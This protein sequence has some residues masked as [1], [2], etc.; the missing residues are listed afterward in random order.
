MTLRRRRDPCFGPK[1]R[2]SARHSSR[3][4]RSA[5]IAPFLRQIGSQA[6]L[7]RR[8]CISFPSFDDFQH[9]KARLHEAHIK[10]LEL[11]RDTCTSITTLELS[12]PSGHP[13]SYSTACK[14][15]KQ[16]ALD[17]LDA[18]FKA[19]PSL[20]E[21]I[22]NFKVHSEEDLSYTNRINMRD[23]GWTVK[24]T[25]LRKIWISDDDRVEFD[26]EEDCNAY[27]YEQ[28][29]LDWQREEKKEKEWL[30]WFEAGCKERS[31][32]L[33]QLWGDF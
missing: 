8:I 10:N 15:V 5:H 22:V 24:V 28:C 19:V 20:K 26:N 4:I 18:R 21:I 3:S 14:P 11:I 2:V 30:S 13:N 9:D 17:L 32:T 6:S 1:E 23:R 7:I 27:N 31:P 12:L 25:K 33:G 29:R 16:E